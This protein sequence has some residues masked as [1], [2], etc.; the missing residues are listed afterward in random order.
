MERR[1]WISSF[2]LPAAGALFLAG[3]VLRGPF[4]APSVG[5]EAFVQRAT[6]PLYGFCYLLIT[7]AAAL[8]I[9]GYL[10]LRER[11]GGRLASVAAVL[12]VIGLVFLVPLFGVSGVAFPAL[13]RASAAGDPGAFRAAA[14][15]FASPTTLAIFGMSALGVIGN[16]LFAV[17]L[18][19]SRAVPRLAAVLFGVAAAMMCVPTVYPV[20]IAGCAAF[21]AAG[22]FL[23]IARLPAG[24]MW[25]RP[26]PAVDASP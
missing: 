2:V 10:G 23:A 12:S 19:R 3:V 21:L 13:G 4:A 15:A 7:A 11:L 16:V 17:A 18:W 9:L 8:A 25:L 14:D 1:A 26:R 5:A 24:N 20:E 22:L 6:S